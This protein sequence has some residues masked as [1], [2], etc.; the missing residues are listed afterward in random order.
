M[1]SNFLAHPFLALDYVG[2][3]VFALSGALA[4]ARLRHDVVTAAAFA[5]LTGMG[6]NK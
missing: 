1:I 5:I 6:A 2:V 3:A 4:A